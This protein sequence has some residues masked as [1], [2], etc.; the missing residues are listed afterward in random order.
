MMKTK[1]IFLAWQPLASPTLVQG[2]PVAKVRACLCPPKLQ[3]WL[4]KVVIRWMPA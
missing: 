4:N 2:S 1:S 3:S